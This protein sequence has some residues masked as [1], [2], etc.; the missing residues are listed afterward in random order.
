MKDII[1]CCAAAA[2]VSGMATPAN[3]TGMGNVSPEVDPIGACC[4]MPQSKT[5][6]VLNN[7]RKNKMIIPLKKYIIQKLH[8]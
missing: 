6:N 2:P 4:N 5:K 7:K 3:T 8:S 1:E